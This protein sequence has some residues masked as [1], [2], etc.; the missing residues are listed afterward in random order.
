MKANGPGQ[1][2]IAAGLWVHYCRYWISIST[3]IAICTRHWPYLG[4]SILG[5]VGTRRI[6]GFPG[7]AVNFNGSRYLPR[8]RDENIPCQICTYTLLAAMLH[9]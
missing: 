1:L 3:A 9:G 2:H 4:A 8:Y 6:M 7:P 5:V